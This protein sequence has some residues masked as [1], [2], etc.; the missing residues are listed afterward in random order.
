VRGIGIAAQASTSRLSSDGRLRYDAG[1]SPTRGRSFGTMALLHV[2]IPSSIFNPTSTIIDVIHVYT[3]HTCITSM[4]YDYE[5]NWQYLTKSST[6]T[7]TLLRYLLNQ[8]Q[9]K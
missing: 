3:V 7:V 9:S 6:S 2:I 1:P 4:I 5:Y 8:S